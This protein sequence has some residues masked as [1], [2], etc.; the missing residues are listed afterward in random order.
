[1]ARAREP[2][3]AAMASGVHPDGDESEPSSI[4]AILAGSP[5]A[6]DLQVASLDRVV[7]R[8][9]PLG[10]GQVRVRAKGQ[11]HLDEEEVALATGRVERPAVGLGGARGVGQPA[12]ALGA[13]EEEH[14]VDAVRKGALAGPP[15][16]HQ[17][18]SALGP[19][20]DLAGAMGK[21][22]QLLPELALKVGRERALDVQLEPGA[23]K[24]PRGSGCGDGRV[25]LGPQRRELLK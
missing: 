15:Q 2:F 10:A 24:D 7:Q 11:Q 21:L 4:R 3:C 19:L 17:V 8:G 1:L 20:G 12:P 14:L 5:L 13:G 9:E 6:V 22:H 16:P 18:V 23:L 25:E